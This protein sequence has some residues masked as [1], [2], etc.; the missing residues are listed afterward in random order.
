VLKPILEIPIFINGLSWLIP[1]VNC[2]NCQ[3]VSMSF[4]NWGKALIDLKS[5]FWRIFLTTVTRSRHKRT[6]CCTESARKAAIASSRSGGVPV[7]TWAPP[8]VLSHRRSVSLRVEWS[9]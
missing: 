4:P 7:W 2:F 9:L 1:S 6:T 8:L 3:H 5:P